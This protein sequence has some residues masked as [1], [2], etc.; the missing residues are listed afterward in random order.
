MNVGFAAASL[1]PGAVGLLRGAK[2]LG[3][4]AMVAKDA[5]EVASAAQRA[6]QIADALGDTKRFVTIGVTDTA[7]G[8]R[9]VSSSENALRSKALDALANGEVAVTGTG[10]AEVTGINAARQMGLNPTGTAASRGICPSCA[11]FLENQR[12]DLLSPLKK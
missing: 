8:T 5:E 12:V 6:T 10:H 3:E 7:E 9:I 4:A 2:I 1:V 11:K